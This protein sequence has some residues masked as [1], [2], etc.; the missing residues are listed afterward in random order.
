MRQVIEEIAAERQ[1][2]IEEEG[3]DP[4]HDEL[5]FEWELS[6]AA[7]CYAAP[8]HIYVYRRTPGQTTPAQHTFQDP[9]PWRKEDVDKR[10]KHGHRKKLVI[11]AALLV[12]EIE[13]LDRLHL[14]GTVNEVLTTLKDAP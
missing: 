6:L 7:V 1:R 9:W 10:E 11:A 14:D 12:A 3:Y 2:Q 13:R 8:E 5:H 4:K